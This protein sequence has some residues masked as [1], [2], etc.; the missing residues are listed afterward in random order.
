MIHLKQRDD[1]A[2]Q[3]WEAIHDRISKLKSGFTLLFFDR[4]VQRTLG[5][6]FDLKQVVLASPSKLSTIAAAFKQK[7]PAKARKRKKFISEFQCFQTNYGYLS[8]IRAP[9]FKTVGVAH[10][11]H[12]MIEKAGLRVCPYCNRN[13]IG[14]IDRSKG[15]AIH[16]LDHYYPQSL[17]PILALSYYNLIPSCAACNKMKLDVEPE[18]PNPYDDRVRHQQAMK[19]KLNPAGANFLTRDAE[20]D[21]KLHVVDASQ[22]ATLDKLK[23]TFHL[24]EAYQD[25]K[26]DAREALLRHHLYSDDRLKEI[27]RMLFGSDNE[28]ERVRSMVFGAPLNADEIVH[29]SL[30]KLVF[31]VLEGAD[32][33]RTN[34]KKK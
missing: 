24:Q 29:R 11:S 2:L 17:Y 31:D 12:T 22:Q 30:G 20:A 4:L 18:F 28:V 26:R 13:Y 15:V 16:Q 34:G 25:H 10:T 21:L 8:H 1:L 27:A 3:H 32:L 19:F 6:S 9:K 23:E 5:A 14:L 7:I 33:N